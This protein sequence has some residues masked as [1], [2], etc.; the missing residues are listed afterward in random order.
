M[1]RPEELS[2]VRESMTNYEIDQNKIKQALLASHTNNNKLDDAKNADIVLSTIH[3]AKGLEFDNTVV[4]FKSDNNMNEEEKRMYYVAFTRAMNSEY[5]LA[6][7]TV[8]SP[9]IDADYHTI[10]HELSNGNGATPIN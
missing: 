6:Y 4:I 10:L 9:Q 1:H 2:N 8:K 5:I 7:G 3:S